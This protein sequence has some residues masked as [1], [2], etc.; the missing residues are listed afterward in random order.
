MA[1]GTPNE[2]T[3]R[4]DRPKT[5]RR[6]HPR[7]ITNFS[8]TVVCGA[9]EWGAKVINLSLGGALLDL[10]PA[11]TGLPVATGDRL[12]VTIRSRHGG[13]PVRLGGAVVL[14]NTKVGRQPLLA[15]QFDPIADGDTEGLDDLIDE[16]LSELRGRKAAG[17]D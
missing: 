3:P 15:M 14:W 11:A 16:A 5:E 9:R 8:A 6:L 4:P 17:L 1:H 7:A 13:G 12:T 10:G 2:R